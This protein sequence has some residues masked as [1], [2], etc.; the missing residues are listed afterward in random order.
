MFC[1]EGHLCLN[2]YVQI[3]TVYAQ[4]KLPEKHRNVGIHSKRQLRDV[5]NIEVKLHV[6][7]EIDLRRSSA[8]KLLKNEKSSTEYYGWRD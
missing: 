2:W 6:Q 7:I 5:C 4:Q 1:E 3:D 8:Y